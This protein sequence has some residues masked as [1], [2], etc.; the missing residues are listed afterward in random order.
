MLE[1]PLYAVYAHILDTVRAYFQFMTP[2]TEEGNQP[3]QY[4]I[5][6]CMYTLCN[7]LSV[8][9]IHTRAVDVSLY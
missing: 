8:N 4:N 9:Y 7:D 2:S 5:F 6:S 1:K 3:T